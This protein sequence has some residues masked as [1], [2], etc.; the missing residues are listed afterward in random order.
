MGNWV[1]MS[2]LLL[3]NFCI[4]YSRVYL[5][6][7]CVTSTNLDQKII[8]MLLNK[9]YI[10]KYAPPKTESGSWSPTFPQG[11]HIASMRHH[12][13][14]WRYQCKVLVHPSLRENRIIVFT[15][16]NG[17]KPT[18][19]QPASQPAHTNTKG[20]IQPL[21]LN[22]IVWVISLPDLFIIR[23]STNF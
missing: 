22:H 11:L 20:F 12:S 4:E 16:S 1:N 17:W 23:W 18:N 21:V 19:S 7:F 14:C 10:Y 6:T 9:I 3:D 15:K 8:G 13:R 2:V 5:N